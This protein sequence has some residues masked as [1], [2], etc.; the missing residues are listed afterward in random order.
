M[1]LFFACAAGLV[2]RAE[3][4]DVEKNIPVKTAPIVKTDNKDV[5]VPMFRDADKKSPLVAKT[6]VASVA[7][8]NKFSVRETDKA[9]GLNPKIVGAN[10]ISMQRFNRYAYRKSNATQPGVLVKKAGGENPANNGTAD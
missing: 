1:A 8:Q 7:S 5:A 10:K 2:A 4:V 9:R 3:T 6:K